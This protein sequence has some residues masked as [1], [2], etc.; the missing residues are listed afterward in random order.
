MDT[1]RNHRNYCLILHRWAL[2]SSTIGRWG[3][4]VK[5]SIVDLRATPKVS[6]KP[7]PSVRNRE[8]H[9]IH[10]PTASVKTELAISLATPSA[11]DVWWGSPA[12]N[13]AGFR[14]WSLTR[15]RIRAPFDGE[16]IS[17]KHKV[18]QH[19][20]QHDDQDWQCQGQDSRRGGL[21]T[22][23]K[24]HTG[25]KSSLRPVGSISDQFPDKSLP[26]TTSLHLAVQVSASYE[27]SPALTSAW[28]ITHGVI[29]GHDHHHRNAWGNDPPRYAN[30][31]TGGH[32]SRWPR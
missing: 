11:R 8:T 14:A 16:K 6:L 13:L 21:R 15:A 24:T 5:V 27:L 20:W 22:L 4:Q 17:L 12:Y 25:K 1:P 32:A 9:Q 31:P 23:V 26:R 30:A 19:R 10:G 18:T 29:L 7:F 3:F 28:A 2:A